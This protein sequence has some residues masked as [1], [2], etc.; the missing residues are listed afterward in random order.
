LIPAGTVQMFKLSGPVGAITS[1]CGVGAYGDNLLGK[2]YANSL[3]ICEPVHHVVQ[4]LELK[5]EGYSFAGYR[6]SNEADHSFLA[7]SDPWA[8]PVQVKAGP[9]GCLYVV[10]MYRF[11]IEHPRWIPSEDLQK[12]DAR[13]GSELGRIYRLCPAEAKHRPIANLATAQLEEVLKQMASPSA[14]AR[15]LAM[16]QLHWR[17]DKASIPF[18]VDLAKGANSGHVR[19]Q[20]LA[21]LALLDNLRDDLILAALK[22]SS[23]VVRRQAAR[24]SE[25]KAPSEPVRDALIPLTADQ[26]PAVRLQAVLSLGQWRDTTA[27]R[28]L[29]LVAGN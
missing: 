28:A 14:A 23:P 6:P 1:A 13:A 19:M 25:T 27:A 2:E 16:E 3:F 10:D 21:T 17:Q 11:L 18:L 15:D 26:D 5:P 9:D 7:S 20:A 8:R 4:R 29:G 22:D 24:L 12:I